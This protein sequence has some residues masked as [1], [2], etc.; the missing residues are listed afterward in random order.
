[1]GPAFLGMIIEEHSA[2]KL[3]LKSI[4]AVP[5]ESFGMVFRRA[6]HILLEQARVLEQYSQKKADLSQLE[7]EERMLNQNILYCM[8]YLNK[9]E[10]KDSSYSYFLLCSA[11]ENTGDQLMQISKVVGKGS[12]L[13][14]RL[15]RVIEAYTSAVFTSDFKKAFTAIRSFRDSL[16]KKSFA[17]GL[18]FSLAED[19]YNYLGYLVEYDEKK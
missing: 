2:K 12:S 19:L 15:V 3:V 10:S 17:E 8:R 14:S 5:E 4:I 7:A 1:M 11:L 9:Y 18:A 13:P 16:T 6:G